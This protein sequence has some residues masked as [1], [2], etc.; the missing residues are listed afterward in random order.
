MFL[1]FGRKVG[2][3]IRFNGQ[4][5]E[6]VKRLM[7]NIYHSLHSDVPQNLLS[8]VE[9]ATAAAFKLNDKQVHT[10][11][12]EESI[13]KK[14][15]TLFSVADSFIGLNKNDKRMQELGINLVYLANIL[16]DI[17]K[18]VIREET[19][20][21]QNLVLFRKSMTKRVT[22]LDRRKYAA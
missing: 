5:I 6:E 17:I 12:D 7:E 19:I 10:F 16:D 1:S 8:A 2:I 9:D 13:F 18:R 3:Q 4:D 21:I 14:F 20:F 22:N 15:A 11:A